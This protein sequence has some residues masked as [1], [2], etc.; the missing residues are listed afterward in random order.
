[1]KNP[2]SL[3][4]FWFA[5]LFVFATGFFY[6]P[7]WK[8]K[9]T[10]A[11]ISWDV[12]GYYFYLPALFIHKDIKQLKFSEKILTDYR[13]TPDLQQAFLHESGNYVMKY[14]AGQAVQYLPF[15]GVAHLIALNTEYAAD[16]FS[17]P[18]Q[19]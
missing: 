14:P 17:R 6:Y 11:T 10:E 2:K 19:L 16:G 3:Y 13:P 8:M 4:A 9:W 7:K 1:M 5:A 18:Y 15:F 12:S